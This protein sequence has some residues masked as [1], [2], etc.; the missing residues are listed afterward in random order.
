MKKITAEA[1]GRPK[2]LTFYCRESEKKV[3]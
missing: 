1:A 3:C 2:T